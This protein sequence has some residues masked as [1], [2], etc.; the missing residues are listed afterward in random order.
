M[1][2]PLCRPHVTSDQAPE[3]GVVVNEDGKLQRLFQVLQ[4]VDAHPLRQDRA[5]RNGSRAPVNGAG[6]SDAGTHHGGPLYAAFPQQLVQQGH[7]RLD[8]VLRLVAQWQHHGFLGYHAVAQGGQDHAEVPPAEVDANSHGAVAV[9]PHVEGAAAGTGN[10]FRGREA[11]VQHDLD[12]VGDR[13]RGEACLPGEF[14]L[15]GRPAAQAFDDAL[16]VQLPQC[17]L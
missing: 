15:G 2:T 3:I 16:L 13:R 12:D 17:G 6:N 5:L 11:G 10:R 14:S 1:L 8:A 9:E 4:D 7:C